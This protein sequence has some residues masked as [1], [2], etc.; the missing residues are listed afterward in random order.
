MPRA[1]ALAQALAD[2]G[3]RSPRERLDEI[4]DQALA[5]NEANPT[6]AAL[7]AYI[8]DAVKGHPDLVWE[9]LISDP[10]PAV[11]ALIAA[12]NARKQTRAATAKAATAKEQR[13]GAKA[14]VPKASQ[15][16]P[17]RSAGG[18]SGG[19][20]VSARE[21]QA[22]RNHTAHVISALDR[23]KINGQRIRLV[24]VY[25]ARQWLT[26]DG[27]KRRFVELLTANLPGNAVIGEYV[28]SDDEANTL[29]ARAVQEMRHV[30]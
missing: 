22:A 1:T 20:I 29:Y 23:V 16:A 28:K 10:M 18:N 27:V 4:A 14:I 19:T 5:A 17:Q 26:T 13:F 15:S 25:E 3:Y 7:R 8:L 11:R 30:G 9:M 12:A 6:W 24:T 21:D 2:A